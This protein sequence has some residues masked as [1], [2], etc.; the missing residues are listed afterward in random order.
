MMS[1]THAIIGISVASFALG[2]VDPAVLGVAAI[3]S[4]LPDV[5]TS[6]STRRAY[7]V[8]DFRGF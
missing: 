7:F 5:D 4:Q 8:S 1:M 6:K 3:G 2:T